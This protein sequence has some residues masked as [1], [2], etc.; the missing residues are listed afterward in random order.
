M[1]T[2]SVQVGG[3]TLA[4]V[5]DPAAEPWDLVVVHTRQPGSELTWLKADIP[6]LDTTYRLSEI[7][8]RSVV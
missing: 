4:S 3:V 7:G 2:P 5:A 1:L 8:H 6:V